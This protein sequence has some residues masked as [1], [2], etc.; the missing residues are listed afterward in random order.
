MQQNDKGGRNGRDEDQRDRADAAPDGH[1]AAAEGVLLR[2]GDDV[3]KRNPSGFPTG[4]FQNGI[5][6][7]NADFIS[8]AGQTGGRLFPMP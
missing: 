2:A 4:S 5:T 7:C 3:A 8:G 1:T 6:P